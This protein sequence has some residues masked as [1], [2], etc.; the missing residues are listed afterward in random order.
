MGS[1]DVMGVVGTWVAV[2]LALFALLGVVGPLLVWRASKSARNRALAKLDEKPSTSFGFV[3]PG[4]RF[5]PGT[6]L[7]RRVRTPILTESKSPKLLSNWK[8]EY[9]NAALPSLESAGW[10][11][12]GAVLRNYELKFPTKDALVL[13][14][15]TMQLPISIVWLFIFGLIG[16]FGSRSDSGGW[17][18]ETTDDVVFEQALPGQRLGERVRGRATR[19]GRGI[20]TVDAPPEIT[21]WAAAPA[22]IPKRVDGK[23]RGLIGKMKCYNR[24]GIGAVDFKAHKEGHIKGLSEEVLDVAKL[25]WL[26]MGC[27][28]M[29]GGR[30]FHL[31]DVGYPTQGTRSDSPTGSDYAWPSAGSSPGADPFQRRY[32]AE[33]AGAVPYPPRFRSRR[34]H[35]RPEFIE[36]RFWSF[37]EVK[38]PL[39]DFVGIADALG[40]EVDVNKWSLTDLEAS[41][42]DVAA[43]LEDAKRT[44]I[45]CHHNWVRLG[46]PV[47]EGSPFSAFFLRRSDAQLLARVMLQLPLCPQ[48]YLVHVSPGSA[49]RDMLAEACSL[50]PRML[51]FLVH[52]FDKLQARMPQGQMDDDLLPTM[53]K[54]LLMTSN[55]SY[56]RLFASVLY[57]LDCALVTTVDREPDV[58]LFIQ[59]LAMTSPEFRD[60][61][62]Q[63]L[64]DLEACLD[65]SLSFDA[66]PA[67]ISTYTIMGARKVFP[68]DLDVLV[69]DPRGFVRSGT[70]QVPYV[71]VLL[72]V[73]KACLRSTFLETSLDSTPLFDAVFK[74][75]VDV[76]EVC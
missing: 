29:T 30:V 46:P 22:Y 74:P 55:Y 41:R 48:G 43:L 19:A 3:T 51:Y 14:E 36:P 75:G 61:I 32:G 50:L 47:S 28:P 56:T 16:R 76:F 37:V 18:E 4:V 57:D 38:E 27:P 42:D 17:I 58:N 62:S 11:Q 44:F 63:S 35:Q 45:P 6:R 65:S 59:V 23:L 12:L 72:L 64:R 52:H 53:K 20:G 49:C 66:A 34:H 39:V 13:K 54:L 31:E 70:I 7:F 73:L 10:V 26:S 2:G 5:G 24:E 69:D 71:D 1:L 67:T 15:E 33:H 21:T 60:L 25:F 8:S 40:A 68:L 9:T